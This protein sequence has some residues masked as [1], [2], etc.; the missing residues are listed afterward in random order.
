MNWVL[1]ASGRIEAGL[2]H[3]ETELH[4][5]LHKVLSDPRF[6]LL[7]SH[8]QGR[9]VDRLHVVGSAPGEQAATPEAAAVADPV[10]DAVADTPPKT[11][12]KGG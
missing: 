2:E 5:A 12:T 3:L 10:V 7:A 4:D 8:F 6:G 11:S 9:S 1:S